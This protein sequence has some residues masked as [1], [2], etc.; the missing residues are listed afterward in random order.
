MA[1]VTRRALRPGEV[2]KVEDLARLKV[3][4]HCDGAVAPTVTVGGAAPLPAPTVG[5][6]GCLR[7]WK[8]ETLQRFTAEELARRFSVEVPTRDAARGGELVWTWIEGQYV[9]TVVHFAPDDWERVT[10]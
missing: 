6:R 5:C 3:V 7:F 1:V 4:H 10:L 8:L 9:T 2:V